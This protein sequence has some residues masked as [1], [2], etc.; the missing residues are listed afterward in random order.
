MYSFALFDIEMAFFIKVNSGCIV[1]NSDLLMDR[2]NRK[3][4]AAR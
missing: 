4:L 2:L 3:F 1:I